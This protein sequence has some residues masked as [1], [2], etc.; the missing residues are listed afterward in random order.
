[1][2]RSRLATLL[3]GALLAAFLVPSATLAATPTT[4][5]IALS[6]AMVINAPNDY[7]PAIVCKWTAPS[8]G[9]AVKAYKVWRIVDSRPRRLIATVTPDQALRHADRNI[10]AGHVYRY[11]VTAV[12]EAGSRVAYSKLVSVG[13]ARTAD[14]IRLDC[15]YKIDGAT[16][17]VFCNWGKSM[18]PLVTRYTLFRSVNGGPRE[19]IYRS[20][21]TGARSFLDKNVVA[22]QSVK[23]GVVV[24]ASGGRI[25]GVGGPETVLIPTIVVTPAAG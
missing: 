19:A 10:Y 11:R 21:A 9:V 1:M 13:Y 2:R 23:Y 18:R 14:R 20:T 22:G 4:P 24:W 3:A 15:F 16:Q 8:T 25:V 5:T 17:G 12:N 6:C 7:R